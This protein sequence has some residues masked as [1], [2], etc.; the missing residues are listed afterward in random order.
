MD[1]ELQLLASRYTPVD[2][3]LI[4]TGEIA[5]VE[6]TPMDFRELTRIG[7]RIDQDFEQL[8]FGGGYDHNWALDDERAP[9]STEMPTGARALQRVA[10]A[11]DQVSGRQLEVLS[12]Q[13]GVQFYAGNFLDGTITG[14]GG[15]KYPHRGGFCLGNSALSGFSESA[16]LSGNRPAAG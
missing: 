5:P 8:R 7:D 16:E 13:P 9:G 12:T 15:A 4:P 3:T 10:L 14:K 11:R 1:Q 2:E 6:G